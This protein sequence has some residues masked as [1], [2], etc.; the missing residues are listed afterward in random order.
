MPVY[1]VRKRIR[2]AIVYGLKKISPLPSANHPDNWL[3]VALQSTVWFLEC[4]DEKPDGLA[5]FQKFFTLNIV[6][7]I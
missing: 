2:D 4:Y 3:T 5:A 7:A 6:N 1:T